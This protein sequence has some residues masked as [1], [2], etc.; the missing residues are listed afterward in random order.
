MGGNEDAICCA[1]M[2]GVTRGLRVEV[3]LRVSQTRHLKA[4]FLFL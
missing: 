2:D 3:P 4:A 1:T